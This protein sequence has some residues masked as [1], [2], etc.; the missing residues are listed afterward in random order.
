[1]CRDNC[2]CLAARR[3]TILRWYY[4]MPDWFFT[5]KR[6]LAQICKASTLATLLQAAYCLRRL[7]YK[8]DGALIPLRLLFQNRS[9]SLENALTTLR[10]AVGFLR[11]ATTAP[12]WH[13]FCS[14]NPF[15]ERRRT[16]LGSTP[17]GWLYKLH[18]QIICEHLKIVT[19]FC[20]TFACFQPI[21]K[22][23]IRLL[24]KR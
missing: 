2:L 18:L 16:K 13:L 15:T 3:K 10:L 8:V 1:M 4:K 12:Y 19:Y 24:H 21:S 17:F 22:S 14:V 5:Y 6:S 23:W 11:V 9:R 7:F 20:A